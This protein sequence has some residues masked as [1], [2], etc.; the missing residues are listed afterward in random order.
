MGPT[1][2]AARVSAG[3]AVAAVV[4]GWGVGQYPWILVDETTIERRAGAPAALVG[5]LVAA[6]LAAVLVVPPLIYLYTLADSNR[7]GSAR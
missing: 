3:V 2:A 7:V 1:V 5:L 4:A 6:G